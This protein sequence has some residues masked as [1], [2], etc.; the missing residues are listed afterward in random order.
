M[1]TYTVPSTSDTEETLS[2]LFGDDTL[3]KSGKALDIK[4]GNG[5]FVAIY[6][7]DDSS[8]VAA[9]VCDVSF[10]AFAGSSLSMIPA[11]GARD[12]VKSRDLSVDMLNNLNEVMNIIGS[13]LMDKD[14]PHLR[15]ET[16]YADAGELPEN[17]LAIV[18]APTGRANYE[19]DIP[20]YGKAL[21]SLLVT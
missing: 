12:A 4:A 2:M 13:L 8:P 9:S 3:I 11:G 17:A 16:I 6:V 7:N 20:R 15:L 14:T 19:V 1:S 5:N 18:N 21:L 10:A